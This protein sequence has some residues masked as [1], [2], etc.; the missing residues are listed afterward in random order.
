MSKK[1]DLDAVAVALIQQLA[2]ECRLIEAGFDVFS[3]HVLAKD[4]SDIQRQEMR[5]AFMAGAEHVYS[6]MLSM[7]EL[8]GEP[9]VADMRRME[10]I[11]REIDKWRARIAQRVSPVKGSS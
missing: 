3:H 6:S 4:A 10:L 8:G 5:L 11:D 9:T 1:E 7:L 2:D